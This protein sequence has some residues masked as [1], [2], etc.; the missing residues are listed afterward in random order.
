MSYQFRSEIEGASKADLLPAIQVATPS[1][2]FYRKLGKRI[3]DITAVLVASV[4]L[5]VTIALLAFLVRRDGHP[6]FY[7]QKRVGRDG[8][9]FKMWKLRTMVPDADRVLGETLEKDPAAYREWTHHQKLKNDPRITPIGA[10]LRR[11]SL[12]ELPQLWNV[13]TGDMSLVGPRPIMVSQRALYP[14]TEYYALQPGVTG[15]WQVS[16]RNESSFQ[17]RAVYDRDYLKEMSLWTDLKVLI[18]T[19]GVVSRGTG[20]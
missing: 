9:I 3:L 12:D 10:K 14:G 18:R 4:P 1:S 20:C 16:C 6:A 2:G 8:R 17:E 15:Y 5:L 11:T 13:L 7:V 19:I